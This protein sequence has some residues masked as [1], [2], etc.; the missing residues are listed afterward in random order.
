[1]GVWCGASAFRKREVGA[2]GWVWGM[3]G[4]GR[5][6]RGGEKK[7]RRGEE[8]KKERKEKEWLDEANAARR[9]ISAVGDR[10]II[11]VQGTAGSGAGRGEKDVIG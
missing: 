4:G 5:E 10:K 6:E 9:S 3:E 1:G 11:R 8:E 2:E 7:R